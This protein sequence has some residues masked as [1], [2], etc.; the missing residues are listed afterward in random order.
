MMHRVGPILSVMLVSFAWPALGAAPEIVC[1]LTAVS[2]GHLD[3]K[4][5]VPDPPAK[6][7]RLTFRGHDPK[8]G[9]ARMQ[10]D[11]DPA[12]HQVRMTADPG[13]IV[14]LLQEPGIG[15]LLVSTAA[16]ASPDGWSAVAT[17]HQWSTGVLTAELMAGACRY[18]SSKD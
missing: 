10:I 6:P 15:K 3:A 2:A 8:A 5:F 17:R 9:T 1:D 12:E 13:A 4:M 18:R 11:D 7:L 14:Y 16:K